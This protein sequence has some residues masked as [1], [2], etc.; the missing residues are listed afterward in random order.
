MSKKPLITQQKPNI[1]QEIALS[2]YRISVGSKC[3]EVLIYKL[4]MILVLSFYLVNKIIN[5]NNNNFFK[6][7][8]Y[9]YLPRIVSSSVISTTGITEIAAKV[10]R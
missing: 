7:V 3:D 5:N 10:Y 4:Q 8:Q 6:T 2:P 9:F 1:T